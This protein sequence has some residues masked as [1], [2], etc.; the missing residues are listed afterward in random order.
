MN[1]FGIKD[2]GGVPSRIARPNA[3]AEGSRAVARASSGILGRDWD[4]WTVRL[5][6]IGASVTLC[7]TI[8]PFGFHGLPA[9]GLGFFVAMVILLAELRLRHAEISGLVGGAAGAVCGLL[10][11]L[12]VTLAISR[13]AEP[14]PAKSFFEFMALFA[15]TYLGLVIGFRK[16]KELQWFVQRRP[17]PTLALESTVFKLLDTSV[18]IDGRIADIC[19]THFLDG[20]LGLP[21]FVLHELQLVADS[22]DPLKRQRGRRGLEVLQRMQKLPGLEI[23]ILEEDFPASIGVDQKL[24]E[25]AR[26][27][28]S[29]IVTN[30]FNLNKVARVQGIAILNVNELANAMKPAVLPGESMRVLILREG[31][32]SSQGVAYLD[33]GTMVVVDGAR[34]LINRTVDI[35]VTSVHQTPAGKMIFG[36]LD[37]RGE[38]SNARAMAQAAASSR[39]DAT[40]PANGNGGDIGNEQRRP[41]SAEPLDP[42]SRKRYSESEN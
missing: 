14:E 4:S 34:R 28:G 37:E 20:T 19:E 32:E 2:D 8:S 21:R 6:L 36:R 17:T 33:D 40:L 30:D 35:M 27:T 29:K 22:G 9:A 39:T 26:R 12:L 7:Y 1:D 25:L 13:T 41:E 5:A 23:R 10:A 38:Q 11:A 18:L 16:G 42:G 24:M 3:R 31:K 15:F